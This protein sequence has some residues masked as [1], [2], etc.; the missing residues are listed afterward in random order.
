MI[1][2]CLMHDPAV[3][4]RYALNRSSG[5]CYIKDSAGSD[6]NAAQVQ[7]GFLAG[8]NDRF[9]QSPCA[10][11]LYETST[12]GTGAGEPVFVH[13]AH[14]AATAPGGF[15]GE[16]LLLR[17]EA[18]SFSGFSHAS[19]IDPVGL[20]VVLPGAVKLGATARPERDG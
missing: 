9:N 4:V 17:I 16:R 7:T 2:V 5:G 10:K 6:S 8:G 12:F 1:T 18:H 14:L 13:P 19:R 3:P 15:D 20:G 11:P